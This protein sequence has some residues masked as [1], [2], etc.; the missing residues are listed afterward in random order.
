MKIEPLLYCMEIYMDKGGLTDSESDDNTLSGLRVKGTKC[1]LGF[2]VGKTCKLV[3]F[4]FWNLCTKIRCSFV[5]DFHDNL[6]KVGQF[7]IAKV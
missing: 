3:K 5:A 2:F 4:C 1:V 6:R 7:T